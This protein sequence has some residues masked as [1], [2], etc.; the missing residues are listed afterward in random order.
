MNMGLGLS[1]SLNIILFYMCSVQN[2][3]NPEPT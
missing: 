2:T 3:C 1:E